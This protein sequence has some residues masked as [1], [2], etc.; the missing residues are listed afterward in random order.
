MFPA[1]QEAP[2]EA[3]QKKRAGPIPSKG[4]RKPS[5]KARMKK[6]QAPRNRPRPSPAA[7]ERTREVADG[8]PQWIGQANPNQ[9]DSTPNLIRSTKEPTEKGVGMNRLERKMSSCSCKSIQ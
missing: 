9:L 2:Q 8:G 4:S 7:K 3:S 5:R 1:Q 6:R